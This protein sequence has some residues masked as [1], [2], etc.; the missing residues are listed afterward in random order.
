MECIANKEKGSE[1][2]DPRE[3]VAGS[4]QANGWQNLDTELFSS[5]CALLC[6]STHGLRYGRNDRLSC[7]DHRPQ[8]ARSF[9]PFLKTQLKGMEG[10]RLLGPRDSCPRDMDACRYGTVQGLFGS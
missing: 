6:L 8:I 7:C 5:L 3:K 1:C 10:T 2:S 9:S 4:V